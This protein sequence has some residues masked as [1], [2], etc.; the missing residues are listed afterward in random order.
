MRKSFIALLTATVLLAGCLEEER[1]TKDSVKIEDGF[2]YLRDTSGR[3]I[4][5]DSHISVSGSENSQSG[6]LHA[7]VVPEGH[8][9]YAPAGA[10]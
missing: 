10:K 5:I 4:A 8:I 2:I 6:R 3:C 7:F 1:P 9:C